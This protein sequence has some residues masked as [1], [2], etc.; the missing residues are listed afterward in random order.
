M[1]WVARFFLLVVI[2]S[3]TELYLLI[4]VAERTSLLMT[5]ALC[6]LTGVVGGAMVRRQGLKTLAAIQ[7]E[8]SRGAMPAKNIVSGLIL[9]MIGTFL[10]TPGFL[11]DTMAFLMLIPPV[12]QLVASRLV[13]YFKRRIRFQNLGSAAQGSRSQFEKGQVIEVE[14]EVVEPRGKGE[15]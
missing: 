11:T 13:G 4:W 3:V 10:L 8:L 14:A 15:L 2:L 5:L 7:K 12:R 9:L 6:V 1:G